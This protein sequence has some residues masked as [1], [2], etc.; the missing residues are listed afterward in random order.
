MHDVRE[1]AAPGY[2]GERVVTRAQAFPLALIVLDLAA[3]V[4]YAI[5]PDAR[6]AIYWLC[7]AILTA[8]VTF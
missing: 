1:D 4:V 5:E 6:R 8:T 2:S 3:A 7:A